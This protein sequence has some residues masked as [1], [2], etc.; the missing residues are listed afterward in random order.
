M[1]S[2]NIPFLFTIYY[3]MFIKF[4]YIITLVSSFYTA[5][6]TVLQ[7]S[8]RTSVSHEQHDMNEIVKIEMS[9]F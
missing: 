4:E 8:V 7:S 1:L 6:P 9:I 3:N 5:K 2:T